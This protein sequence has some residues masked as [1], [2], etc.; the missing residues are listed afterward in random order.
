MSR[1]AKI[2]A[3]VLMIAIGALL[4]GSVASAAVP[5]VIFP[6]GTTR[7][8]AVNV[9]GA[10]PISTGLAVW[11]DVPG[12]SQSLPIP[13]G[14]LGDVMVYFCGE[15]RTKSQ[16]FARA[17]ILPGPIVLA[18]AQMQIREDTL[19][20]DFESQ[21]ANY[22]KVKVLAPAAGGLSVRMQWRVSAGS[23]AEM[24]N[25]SMIVVVNLY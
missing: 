12:L 14:K 8:A 18:P 17:V 11:V 7:Y 16:A 25:R 15:T 5:Q 13:P 10:A 6:V 9:S 2:I 24:R 23:F 22:Y 3:A 4:V 21:C 1:K 19:G 20:G